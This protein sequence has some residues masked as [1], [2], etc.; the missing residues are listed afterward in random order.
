MSM[1]TAVRVLC[2]AALAAGSVAPVLA[3]TWPGKPIRLIVAQAPGSA[4]DVVARI[5]APALAE[6]LGQPLLV[7]NR[8]GAGGVLGTELAAK[9]PA[10]GYTLLLANISTHGVNPALHRK[11]PFDPVR[12]FTPVSM[13]STTPNLLVVH[14]SL[15]VKSAGE[16]VALA[17]KKP[18][19]LLYATPGTGSS[20]H[21][22]TEL[23]RSMAGFDSLHV[24]YKGTP[25]ALAATI[26]G[27]ASWMMPTL[28]SALPH[29]KANRLRVLAVTS[30]QRLEDL[31]EVP[32]L[33]EVFPG[34][35]VVS[36]YALVGPAGL[37]RAIVER[38]NQEVARA[39]AVAEVRRALALN[40]MA[41]RTGT[42][43]QLAAY[44]R[45]DIARWTRVV[46]EAKIAIE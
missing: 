16:L 23:F 3:Q 11:L 25:P 28:T 14:P 20:Q 10:D 19:A 45:D 26:S 46:R 32:A 6:A 12:D 7:D 29:V 15:P 5:L 41:V 13:V 34:F 1:H 43:E 40:G 30:A 22:A 44:I 33:A 9:A 31:P 39:S 21:L 42:P 17:R 18:G 35:E 24:P 4:T 27:E 36:W 8:T 37:P 2:A 38:L